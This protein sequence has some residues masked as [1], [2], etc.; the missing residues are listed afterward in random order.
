MLV[1]GSQMNLLTLL[2]WETLSQIKCLQ[3]L[4]NTQKPGSEL[5]KEGAPFLPYAARADSPSETG[6]TQPLLDA[7]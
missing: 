5:R 6:L 4:S 3:G 2:T 7:Q 1:F